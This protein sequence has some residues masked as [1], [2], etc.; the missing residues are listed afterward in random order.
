MWRTSTSRRLTRVRS[1]GWRSEDRQRDEVSRGAQAGDGGARLLA[2][3]VA[4]TRVPRKEEG[5]SS[6]LL[7][8]HG[9]P[10]QPI[11]VDAGGS[12]AKRCAGGGALAPEGV[13]TGGVAPSQP[14]Q[15]C[16]SQAASAPPPLLRTVPCQPPPL[17]IHPQGDTLRA[18]LPFA[19]TAHRAEAELQQLH[20]C[21]AGGEQIIASAAGL[22]TGAVS[23]LVS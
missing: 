2:V 21:P 19:G 3:P 14:S 4:L 7:N 16:M 18:I 6:P 12:P 1:R 22:S 23:S 15:G 20:A 10:C 8:S 5:G 13:V 11:D 9:S 17:T